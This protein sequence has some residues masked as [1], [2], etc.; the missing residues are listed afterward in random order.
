MMMIFEFIRHGSCN[1][2]KNYRKTNIDS[3]SCIIRNTWISTKFKFFYNRTINNLYDLQ[4]MTKTETISVTKAI[5]DVIIPSNA[6][7]K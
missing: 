3:I 1:K 7:N 4:L 2:H 5:A 6:R